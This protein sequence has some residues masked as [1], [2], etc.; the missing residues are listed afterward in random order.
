MS[1]RNATGGGAYPRPEDMF[2]AVTVPGAL[3]RA[4]TVPAG[5]TVTDRHLAGTPLPYA[6]LAAAARRAA[7]GLAT[8][9]VR[10]GDRVALVSSTS[11]AFLIGLFGAWRAGAVPVVLPLPHRVST[12]TEAVDGIRRRLDHVDARCAVVADAFA[13][14]A[15]DGLGA[16]RPVL[17]CGQLAAERQETTRP[18]PEGADELAYLQFTSGTTGPPRAVAL[19]HRQMLT[20]AAVCCERLRLDR[21]RSLHLSWLPLHHDMGLISALAAVAFR[22]PLVL[23]PPEEF[24]S[25]PDSWPEALSHHRA[26]ST[27]A[28]DFA[29]G[30]AA[31]G[32]RLRPRPLDLSALEVCGDGAEPLHA[33][34]V[35]QFTETGARHGLRP[36][37]LTPMYGLAEAALAVTMGDIDRPVAWDHVSRDGLE[38]G[39]YAHPVAPDAPDARTLAVCGHPVPGV[40]VEI[41]DP[42]GTP[43][44]G[45]EVG[46]IH[47]HS[48]ALMRGYWTEPGATAE[49]L[50]DGW[51]RTGDLGYRTPDGLVVCGRIKDMII[52]GGRN[53]YPEDYEYVAAGVDGVRPVCAAFALPG[54]ERMAV[55]VEPA[56]DVHDH[57]DLAARVMTALREHLGHAPDKV[58]VLAKGS[59]PRTTSGKVRRG[60]CRELHLAG[61]LPELAR[62]TR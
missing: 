12:L 7:T 36:Q 29:Y 10:P 60:R 6:L 20:N 14:L 43:L 54:T 33:A 28:P 42:E 24:L 41:R 49:A 46:E 61:Q 58:L 15:S 47:V 52:V 30:L 11:A 21:G 18:L 25:R 59:I 19:T 38:T 5:I 4:A 48:P 9:G 53:L 37:A 32:L 17:T 13:D 26:T 51:L 35:A 16:H 39:G 40:R 22:I 3:E 62:R 8:A 57:T 55:A 44:A 34:A 2:G 56:K 31:R 23:M 45:R 27:V 50:H 1:E